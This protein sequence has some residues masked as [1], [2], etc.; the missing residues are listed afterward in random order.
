VISVNL[1]AATPEGPGHRG[2]QR[3]CRAARRGVIEGFGPHS[4]GGRR[5]PGQRGQVTVFVTDI[6]DH[7]AI[8]GV[9][10]RYFQGAY[11]AST[12]V[13][14]AALAAPNLKVEM[15]TVAILCWGQPPTAARQLHGL[16]D[17]VAPIVSSSGGEPDPTRRPRTRKP[18]RLRQ[19]RAEFATSSDDR[20][21]SP[22]AP[23]R[24]R[25]LRPPRLLL[26]T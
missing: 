16:G 18:K 4:G 19:L 12:L 24:W 8:A 9:R 23:S 6:A 2:R 25:S 14:V 13:K 10:R 5:D 11:P 17:G 7:D 26:T 21:A 20:Q 15:G 3:D 1:R 22:A